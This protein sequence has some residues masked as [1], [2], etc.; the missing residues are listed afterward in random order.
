MCGELF[1]NENCNTEFYTFP[2]IISYFCIV[3]FYLGYRCQRAHIVP[4]TVLKNT[5]KADV[6]SR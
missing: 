2:I 5:K 3:K 1:I 6:I 4:N